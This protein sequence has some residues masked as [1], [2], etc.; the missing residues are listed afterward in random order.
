M[1]IRGGRIVDVAGDRAGDVRIGRD[2]R[3]AATGAGLEPLSGEEVVD[4]R[5]CLVVPGGVDAHTHL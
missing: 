3:I 2:G 5:S 1:L 4:A